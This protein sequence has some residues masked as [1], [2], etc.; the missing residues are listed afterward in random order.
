[1]LRLIG[2]RVLLGIPLL[3]IVSALVF[4][5][6]AIAPGDP[7]AV[8]LGSAA[9]PENIAA[10]K[11]ELG[12]DQPLYIQY[13]HWLQGAVTGDLGHSI[14]TSQAVT[15]AMET[16]VP[17]TL[18]LAIGATLLS[19]LIGVAL[20]TLSAIRG[21]AVGATT[22]IL[23][24]LGFAV[25][26]FWLGLILVDLVAVQLHLLPATSYV[27]FNTSPSEWL[28]H[29]V[30]PIFTLA[31]FGVTGIAKQTR[32]SMREAMARDF[33]VAKRADGLPERTIVLHALRNAAIPI[34]TMIG[35]LFIG[36]LGGTVLVEAVYGM[37]GLGSLAVSS[38]QTGDL[39]M[40]QGIAVVFAII[41]VVV[42][43][44][45]DVTYGW[46]NPKARVA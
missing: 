39:P 7:A 3:F 11:A 23:A 15:K 36:L 21:G 29:L 42:N 12:L 35:V 27:A 25:P 14:I 10:L 24:M 18:S 31:I 26:S 45:F 32:D 41:V 30:L 40:L 1:M 4:V 22:D 28:R 5:L 16:R 37:Q 46:L 6:T 34:V 2:R 13:W 9:T 17:V 44:V 38:A 19:A 20:G 8:V 43:I 33:I